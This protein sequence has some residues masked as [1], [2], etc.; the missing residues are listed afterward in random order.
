M[1]AWTWIA[2]TSSGVLS[3]SRPASR[4]TAATRLSQRKVPSSKF[5]PIPLG[6]PVL[7]SASTAVNNGG[8]GGKTTQA[9]CWSTRGSSSS[10]MLS[11]LSSEPCV[12]AGRK[13]ARAACLPT[14]CFS[15]LTTRSH[16]S[17]AS[18]VDGRF[19]RSKREIFWSESA[20]EARGCHSQSAQVKGQVF[21]VC[22]NSFFTAR[23]TWPHFKNAPSN[24][25][26]ALAT[27]TAALREE[28]CCCACENARANVKRLPMT[29]SDHRLWSTP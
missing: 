13:D 28:I 6:K 22:C 8:R 17:S 25:T 1:D 7:L 9:S 11:A 20:Q 4:I 14:A 2:V 21:F 5:V 23:A 16:L 19:A 26:S 24:I 18:A 15:D 27:I 10:T 12:W 29:C 3:T